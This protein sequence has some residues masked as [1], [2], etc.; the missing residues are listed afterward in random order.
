[1]KGPIAKHGLDE[2]GLDAIKEAADETISE[3]LARSPVKENVQDAMLTLRR[4][5]AEY[6]LG[7][8]DRKRE[9]VTK[10]ADALRETLGKHAG[11][12]K[13]RMVYDAVDDAITA[14]LGR[15]AAS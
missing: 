10:H 5:Y 4:A 13:A 6:R 2:E 11:D 1:M 9:E 15:V 14:R 12:E 3:Q 7:F 8:Y